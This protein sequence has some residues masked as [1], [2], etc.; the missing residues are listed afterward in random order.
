[1][2]MKWFREA[3]AGLFEQDLDGPVVADDVRYKQMET[4]TQALKVMF[5]ACVSEKKKIGLWEMR[6][7]DW[8]K[9]TTKKGTPSKGI[10]WKFLFPYLQ[11]I[12]DDSVRVLSPGTPI[13][14]WLDRA[15]CHVARETQAELT[16]L[17]GKNVVLQPPSSPD[18]NMLDSGVFPN[19]QKKV[20][21]RGANSIVDIR[22]AVN[23]VW[24]AAITSEHLSKVASR[25][26][27]NL[28][29]MKKLKGGNWY[30]E[31]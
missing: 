6:K 15:P 3:A 4:Q 24:D 2:D 13:G 29:M 25:V 17:F 12:K 11:K 5:M 19:M 23:D 31:R 8:A 20:N 26:R 21:L 9:F 28:I 27:R 22:K 16:R 14:I 18:L 7:E 1:M 10:G 30:I